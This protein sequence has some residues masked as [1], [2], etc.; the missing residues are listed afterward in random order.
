M[1]EIWGPK[2]GRSYG[3]D[4]KPM[5]IDPILIWDKLEAYWIRV[6]RRSG[7]L[8]YLGYIT[9]HIWV[10][11]LDKCIRYRSLQDPNGCCLSHYIVSL[12]TYKGQFKVFA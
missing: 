10:N 2:S 9:L 1:L 12:A 7:L 11:L 8:M 6:F 3:Y 4:P 5:K